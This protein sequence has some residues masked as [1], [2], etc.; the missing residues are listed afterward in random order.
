MGNIVII[1]GSP[2]AGKSTVAI[3]NMLNERYL[4]IV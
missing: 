3:R 4:R 2:G 1:S